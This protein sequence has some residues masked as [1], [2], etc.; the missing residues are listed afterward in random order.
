[1]AGT[2]ELGAWQLQAGVG[3]GGSAEKMGTGWVCPGA[4][5]KVPLRKIHSI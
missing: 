4:V 2:A 1:M 5:L 3:V